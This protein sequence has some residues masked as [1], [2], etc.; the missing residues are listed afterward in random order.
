VDIDDNPTFLRNAASVSPV[1]PGVYEAHL[2]PHYTVLGHPNGGY[3][4]CVMASA[5][6]AGVVDEGSP[7][8]HVTGISTNFISG[9][10][11]DSVQLHVDVRRIGKGASFAHVTMQQGGEVLVESTVTLGTLKDDSSVRYHD[12]TVPPISRLED[13]DS[14]WGP[15]EDVAMM[16]K[17]ELRLDQS[18][19]GWLRN[20]FAEKAEIKG[21]MRLNDGDASWNAWNVLFACDAMPPATLPIGS[22]GWVPTLQ[23]TS[24]VRR[25]P[26]GEWLRI[27]QWCQVIADGLVD[28]RCELFDERG[29]L[30]ACSSQL[31]MVRFHT[32]EA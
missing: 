26:E 31:A 17:V 10:T 25:I 8:L 14:S 24:Y 2:S 15:V 22:S 5:A 23:L 12:A 29:E 27:R 4:Q 28:E 20:E 21:W 9:P 30:V 32:R 19:D 7:H 18:T 1:S 6:L 3:L 16:G 13:S 11:A